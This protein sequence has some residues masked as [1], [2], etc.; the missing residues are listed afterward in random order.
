MPLDAE[1]EFRVRFLDGLHDAV[2]AEGCKGQAGGNPIHRLMVLAVDKDGVLPQDLFQLCAPADGDGVD[3]GPVV[4][5]GD[6]GKGLDVL[7]QRAAQDDIHH[8]NAPAD[9]QH[10]LVSGQKG[11]QQRRLGGVAEEARLS[12]GGDAF[13]PVELGVHV[14]AAGQQQAVAGQRLLHGALRVRKL[15]P[16]D[17]RP[18]PRKAFGIFGL[19]RRQL[20]VSAHSWHCD[21]NTHF[22]CLAFVKQKPGTIGSGHFGG[23]MGIRTPERF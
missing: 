14:A 21:R 18:G 17:V 13:L 6:M 7:I 20:R 12:T 22:N 3:L 5:V 9:A 15:D 11:S 8:L 10:R 23:K 16:A 2:F 19:S 4:V 1:A